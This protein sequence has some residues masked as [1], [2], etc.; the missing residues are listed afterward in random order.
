MTEDLYQQRTQLLDEI[1]RIVDD[2]YKG[3]PVAPMSRRSLIN[4]L[5]FAVETFMP[6][7]GDWNFNVDLGTEWKEEAKV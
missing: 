3:L 7:E 5:S 2:F 4:R 1:E 6:C